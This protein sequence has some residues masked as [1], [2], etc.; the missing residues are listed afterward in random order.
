MLLCTIFTKWPTSAASPNRLAHMLLSGSRAA[1]ASRKG[2]MFSKI[3]GLPPAIKD[4]PLRAPSSPP[5]TPRPR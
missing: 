3:S 2:L 4:A 1:A 5:E